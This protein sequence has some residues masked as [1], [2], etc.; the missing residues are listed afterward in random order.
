MDLCIISAI[1]L[2]ALGLFYILKFCFFSE[3]LSDKNHQETRD[4]K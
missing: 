4:K 1:I 2:I 3:G